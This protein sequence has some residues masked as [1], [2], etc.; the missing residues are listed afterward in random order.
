M[1]NKISAI[2]FKSNNIAEIRYYDT[3]IIGKWKEVNVQEL[4]YI[5]LIANGELAEL[6]IL[7]D[8]NIRLY[9]V[10]NPTDFRGKY[11]DSFELVKIK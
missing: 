4:N 9:F 7:K 5:E 6:H 2:Y 11:C 8:S 10:S 3:M 1:F